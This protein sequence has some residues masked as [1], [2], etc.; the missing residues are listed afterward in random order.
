MIKPYFSCLGWWC[1]WAPHSTR[2]ETKFSH[3]HRHCHWLGNVKASSAPA[4]RWWWWFSHVT[5]FATPW[6][7]AWQASLSMIFSRQEYGSRLPFP[8]PGDL[9]NPGI[10]RRSPALQT[11]SLPIVLRGKPSWS[12]G[13]CFLLASHQPISGCPLQDSA[14]ILSSGGAGQQEELS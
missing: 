8:S 3:W 1:L 11:D 10:K 12:M 13:R 9:P 4:D 2:C 5:L 14:R 7:V 6:T